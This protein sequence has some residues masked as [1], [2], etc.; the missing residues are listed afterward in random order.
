MVGI[1]SVTLKQN[2]GAIYDLR[3]QKVDGTL[4]KGIYIQNGKKIMVK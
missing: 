1:E 2:D 4:R 3:G